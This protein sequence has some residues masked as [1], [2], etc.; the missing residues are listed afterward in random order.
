MLIKIEQLALTACLNKY[1][2]SINNAAGIKNN[3][4]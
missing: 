3:G 1:S 2:T 4:V